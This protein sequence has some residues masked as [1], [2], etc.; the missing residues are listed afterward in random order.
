MHANVQKSTSTTLP[1]SAC[2]DSG[3][4]FSHVVA[5][6]SS[7]SVPSTGRADDGAVPGDASATKANVAGPDE[8]WR[9]SLDWFGEARGC[10]G[11][12]FS[13]FSSMEEPPSGVNRASS[14]VSKPNATAVTLA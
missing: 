5:P 11:Q 2:G 3:G 12:R 14:P 13:N 7:G 10:N 4:E 6:E 9:N 8:A 1:R